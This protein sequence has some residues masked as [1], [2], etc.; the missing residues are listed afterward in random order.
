MGQGRVGLLQDDKRAALQSVWQATSVRRAAELWE[1]I[2]PL[3]ATLRQ[4]HLLTHTHTFTSP[5]ISTHTLTGS[6]INTQAALSGC[7]AARPKPRSIRKKRD[8]FRPSK[9]TSFLRATCWKMSSW[10]TYDIPASGCSLE[11]FVL[12]KVFV[13][14]YSFK[15]LW[16]RSAR[17]SKTL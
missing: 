11:T 7:D 14:I 12:Q 15:P 6:F 8:S 2:I 3:S 17:W 9:K 1:R 10:T 16:N 13:S 4:S 5:Y